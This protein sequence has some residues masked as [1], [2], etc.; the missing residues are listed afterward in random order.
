MSAA[1]GLQVS[2]K[3][4]YEG[5]TWG[6]IDQI[7]VYDMESEMSVEGIC[8]G[9]SGQTEERH[10]SGERV[11]GREGG[12]GESDTLRGSLREREGGDGGGEVVFGP[13]HLLV[14]DGSA[15]WKTCVQCLS[16]FI[17]HDLCA[18]PAHERQQVLH[19]YIR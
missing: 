2:H 3:P 4:K 19:S 13:F 12:K 14:P 11:R 10:P 8:Q 5:N 9:R 15:K 6:I 7:A 17:P 1:S 16:T 18:S